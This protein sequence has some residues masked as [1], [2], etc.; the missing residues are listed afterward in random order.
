MDS[1][2]YPC[3]V[4]YATITNSG[5]LS[6][7]YEAHH[8]QC[9]VLTLNV[10]G[11]D[12]VTIYRTHCTVLTALSPPICANYTLVLISSPPPNKST[13]SGATIITTSTAK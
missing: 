11:D 5:L 13:L 1:Y 10:Q 6:P 2:N 8:Q 3:S 4:Y 7:A 9:G 12:Y